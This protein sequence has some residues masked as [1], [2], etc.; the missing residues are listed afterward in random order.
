MAPA[1]RKKTTAARKR[2]AT[3]PAQKKPAAKASSALAAM[4]R[5]CLSLPDTKETLTWGQPHFRVDDKIFS[6]CGDEKGR[7][8]IGFKLEM[9]HAAAILS[10]PRFTRAPY[11]GRYGWVSLDASQVDDWKEVEMLVR[12][13][14]SLIAPKASTAKLRSRSSKA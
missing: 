10:D 4:R 2:V 8:T 9:E 13:S 3:K 12:E 11:V 7:L 1:K 6:G 5:I 14:Y